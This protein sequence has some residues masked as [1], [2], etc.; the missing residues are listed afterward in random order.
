MTSNRKEWSGIT[1]GGDLGLNFLIALVGHAPLWLSYAVLDIF[2]PVHVLFHKKEFSATRDYF[3]KRFGCGSRDSRRKAYA[4]HRLFGQMMFDRFRFYSK[5][6]E[7][8]EVR[9]DG[10]EEVE[11]RLSRGRGFV[12]AGAHV[13]SM[14]MVGYIF[15]NDRIPVSA[16]VFGGENKVMQSHRTKVMSDHCV[17]MIPVKEDM[18]HIF[19]IKNAIDAGE[20]VSMPCDRLFGSK[21]YY[22]LPFLGAV[23]RF[24]VG[25]FVL[26]AQTGADIVTV[27]AFKEGRRSYKVIARPLDV[28]RE[29]RN[30][31][32]VASELASEYVKVLEEMVRMYPEQ[33]FNFYDFWNCDE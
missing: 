22:E 28:V 13:G 27:F 25:A 14:E 3:S 31:R 4:C 16:L 11:D 24:P 15:G 1:G 19:A 9:V 12:L 23:A 20:V 6:M 32:A 30:I 10:E 33:W 8:L 5:G 26:A 17:K 29:G 21:K 7:G 18:S 2:L